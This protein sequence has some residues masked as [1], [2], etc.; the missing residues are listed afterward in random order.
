MLLTQKGIDDAWE[1]GVNC[2][3][4][5]AELD[6]VRGPVVV[7]APVSYGLGHLIA[8]FAKLNRQHPH[9]AFELRLED[10]AVDLLAAG[11]DIAVRIGM[12]MPDS[13]ALIARRLVTFRR[14]LV[15]SASYLRKQRIPKH[16]RELVDHDL[17]VHLRGS[18]SVTRWLFTHATTGELAEV[19]P[20]ARLASSSPLALREWALVGAG[21]ALI[22]AWLGGDLKPLLTAWTTPPIDVYALH[23][24]ETRG[25]ARIRAVVDA[26][27]AGM[28]DEA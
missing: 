24:A 20:R 25:A 8:R 4:L 6:D 26:L 2:D 23:R 17:L 19:D 12:T 10:H 3:A 18:P 14:V 15:A 22:P 27:A 13:T 21:I 7:S 1:C 28:R 5:G 11:V 16:P 9:L